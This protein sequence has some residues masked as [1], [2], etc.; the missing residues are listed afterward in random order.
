MATVLN[1]IG[2]LS[3]VLLAALALTLLLPRV[4]R[5]PWFRDG[6]VGVVFAIAGV[7][8][9]MDPVVVS[10]GII[11]DAR[12]AVLV[13]AAVFGGPVGAILSL[14]PVA[15]LRIAQGGIGMTG[16][17]VGMAICVT[18][19]LMFWTYAVR[20]RHQLVVRDFW[21]PGLI[22]AVSVPLS[23][24][25]LP[26]FVSI[27]ISLREVVLTMMILNFIGTG[28]VVF[29]LCAD[30]ERVETLSRLE[31]FTANT[32]GVLYQKVIKP[33]GAVSY[34]F[35]STG[36][37]KLLDVTR[38]EVERDPTSWLRWM[39]PEDRET[40]D[41]ANKRLAA[42]HSTAP[43]R[44]EARHRRDDGS[45]V[46]LRTDAAAR[47]MPDGSVCWDGILTDVTAE[48]SL[49]D[50]RR[51]VD[52][53]R[54][55]ALGELADQL[56]VT[57]G[58]ALQEVGRSVEGMQEAATR[59][60]ASANQTTLRAVDVTKEAE[61]ASLRVSSVA[62]AAEEIDASIRELTR[63]TSHADQTVR[64]AASYV[65]STRRDVAGLT[66]AADKVSAVL[67]FIEDIAQRTNLLALNA[68]I[69]AAR[70]GAAGRGFAV[71]AGEVKN[72][73]EQTQKATRDIAETLQDIR[74][75]AATASEAVAH[76][77]GTMTTI[78]QTSGI[79]ADV[80]SRQA[81]IASTIAADAQAV[82]GST[83]AVTTSVGTV[84]NEARTTGDAA[85]RV[86]EV[87]RQVGEQTLAL[88][89]YVGEFV[90]SV[91]GRL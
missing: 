87:A 62:V 86:V 63:Q 74:G 7:A 33:S 25:F 22:A 18:G 38:E 56:E 27:L 83:N 24:V 91:R 82:A 70:A 29:L 11:F 36:I 58:K 23:S 60:A 19:G 8:G 72:L 42:E 66:D 37:E 1:L 51:T 5:P 48:R 59:M 39:V 57:V 55:A 43:W 45:I 61:G 26:D 54:K 50:R 79:I 4:D 80:V 21:I 10:P 69:E 47:H 88:D 13:L 3:F 30:A 16:G 53:S 15:A 67:D 41:K 90:K 44:F 6:I 2:C 28:L 89:H 85:A 64:D 9:M 68:T 35:A 17:L 84:G 12:N 75:A 71:V 76:I 65:R 31:A 40:L 81:D 49:E 77:E 20:W 52:D 34:K 32:P 14:V 78:E 73:A 46:W